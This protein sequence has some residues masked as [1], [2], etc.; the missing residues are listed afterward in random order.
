MSPDGS[1]APEQDSPSVEGHHERVAQP[2]TATGEGPVAEA[3][4]IAADLSSQE[5]PLGEPGRR[6]DRRSPFFI[7]MAAAAGVAVTYGAVELLSATSSMLLLIFVAF[8]LALG[9][10]PAVSWL[11]AHRLPRW[12]ATTVVFVVVLALLAGFIAAAIPPLSQQASQLIAQAPH[13][14]QQAQ[15]HSSTIGRLNERFQLQQRLT[16][17]LNSSG[18]SAVNQVISAG[19]AVFE[20][21]VDTVIVV[22]LTVYFLVDLPRIRTFLYRLVPH[23][24]RPRAILIGDEVFA[25]VGAYLLGNLVIS[26]VAGAATLIWLSAFNVPYPL[27]LGILVALLDLVPV[28][29]STIAGIVVAAAAFTVSLPVGLATIVFFVVFR[30]AEDYLLIPRIIGRAVDVPA[31]VT[32]VAVLIGGAVL[33]IVGALVAIP[34]A[35]AIQLIVQEMAYPRLDST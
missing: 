9:L 10:E 29:G 16:D 8:F 30:L 20:A 27:L 12:A 3:E 28:V 5:R 32:V 25:K 34:V 15:D 35:A 2:H 18:G 17:L 4:Q 7:G 23:S 21:V 22:V 19:S 1:A 6:F 26:F 24:R 31:L 13:Y 14:L 11:A 33:G